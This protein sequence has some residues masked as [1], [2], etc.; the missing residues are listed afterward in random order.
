MQLHGKQIRDE[1]IELNKLSGSGVVEFQSATMSFGTQ[2][3]LFYDNLPSTQFEVANKSYVDSVVQGLDIKESVKIKTDSLIT[4]SGEYTL[5]GINLQEGDRVLVNGQDG[6]N[7]DVNN[8]IWV[9]KS[10]SWVRPD[11]FNPSLGTVTSGSFTFVEE[12]DFADCGFVLSTDNLIDENTPIIFVQFSAAGVILAGTGLDK[13][14]NT[15]FLTDTGVDAGIYSTNSWSIPSLNIDAQ[16]RVI[17]A[18]SSVIT[19][20]PA[21]DG[22]YED[23]IFTDLTP[24]TPVGFAVDRINEIL[25]LLAP[26]PPSTN[27]TTAFGNT[28]PTLTS[29][30]L[31]N[32]PRMIGTTT[33]TSNIVTT[34]TPTFTISSNVGMGSAARTKDGTF[35][36]ILKDWDDNIIES[37]TIDTNSVTKTTGTLRWT[38]GD[39]Y[40]IQGQTGFWVGVTSFN[41]PTF[42]TL[43][44]IPRGI[45]PQKI[46]FEHP[47]SQ[48]KNSV[49]F[50]VDLATHTPSVNTLTIGTLP[51]M[52]RYISGVPSLS[53][54]ETIPI[55]SFVINNVSTYFYS[56]TGAYNITGTG[57]VTSNSNP[58]DVIPSTLNENQTFSNKEATVVSTSFYTE[59]LSIIITPKNRISG[60]GTA[61]TKTLNNSTDGY[62]RIDTV[63]D[64]TLRF[65]SGTGNFPSVGVSYDNTQ[66]GVNLS[67]NTELQLINGYYR[68]PQGNYTNFGGPNYTGITTG[69]NISGVEWRWSTF[70]LN[71]V[72]TP[73][74]NITINFPSGTPT[75]NIGTNYSDIKMY[76]KIGN[77]GWLDATL[78]QDTQDPFIDGDGALTVAGSTITSRI[79]TFGTIARSG[80][81]YVRIGVKSTNTSYVFRKPTMN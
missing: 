77:S 29:S 9:V 18:S 67:T 21:E 19:L 49:T 52:T 74:N 33:P 61:Q 73:V 37:A 64:E 34:Q 66:S 13:S 1:S 62:L 50:Y 11:D 44:S 39:P 46:K 48:T 65:T 5:Q 51:L 22:T 14:G 58:F 41:A 60:T 35:D 6:N 59:A 12:G 42:T 81:V 2:S 38:I 25:L 23:G 7:P 8:G 16:G 69:D 36:F 20:G 80:Q 28:V 78:P 63:S 56:N 57:I 30:T 3:R 75:T 32:T 31:T 68:W 71:N 70:E 53:G 27:W 26:T 17:S 43:T 45:T 15:I 79:V 47:T 24:E 76:V 55:T 40:T 54:G 4:L 10:S 72:T